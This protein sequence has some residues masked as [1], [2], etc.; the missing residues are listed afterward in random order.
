[1]IDFT[2]EDPAL[3]R[4]SETCSFRTSVGSVQ[5]A[6]TAVHRWAPVIGLMTMA[7]TLLPRPLPLGLSVIVF[8]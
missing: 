1:M 2:H 3:Y 4:W 7:E 6:Y 5:Q 8:R